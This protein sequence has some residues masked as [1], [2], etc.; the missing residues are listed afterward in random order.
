MLDQ[1]PHG[2]VIT[3]YSYKG[4]TGRTMALANVACSLARNQT[5][6]KGILMIDWDLEAPGLHRFFAPATRKDSRG[7]ATEQLD[8]APG[9]IDF[10]WE[11]NHIFPLSESAQDGHAEETSKALIEKV[12]IQ[13]YIHQTEIAKVYLL[14]AGRFDGEYP[15]R[16]NTFR[17][18][19]FYEKSPDFF[20]ILAEILA[21]QFDYI[22]I[23]SRTGITDTSGICTM[24]MP[25]RL[26]VV[27]VPNQQSL[28]GVADL[29]KRAISY[30]KSSDDLRPLVVFPLPS[31]IESNQ[32]DLREKWRRGDRDENIAGYQSTF[33]ELFSDVYRLDKCILEDYFDNVQIQHVPY[34]AYGEKIAVQLERS[35]DSLSIAKSY[36]SFTDRLLN[37]VNP[38]DY[39]DGTIQKHNNP[40]IYGRA[41]FPSEFAGREAELNR[42]AS[43][44]STGQSIAVIGQP[45]VGKT[46]LLSYLAD[47]TARRKQFGQN[48]DRDIFVYLD[49]LVL[50]GVRTQADFWKY[51]LTP[52]GTL[53]HLAEYEYADQKGYNTFELEQ[54]FGS[55]GR[56]KRKLVLM[57]DEFD[58]LLSHPVL[59]KP[60]F[61]GGLRTLA[62][63]SSGFALVI[64][65]RRS[66][67]QLNRLTQDINPHGS[68]YFNIF[69]ELRLGCL[70]PD[71][72]AALLNTGSTHITAL[73]RQFVQQVSGGHPYLAQAAAAMLWD[74]R[75]EGLAGQE[76]YQFAVQSLY[77]QT[78]PHFADTWNF[79]SSTTRKVVIALALLEV[80]RLLKSRRVEIRGLIEDL[81]DFREE[82]ELL[83]V[84]GILTQTVDGEWRIQQESFLWWFIDEL[85]RNVREETHFSDWLRK[86]NVDNLLT[87][88]DRQSL[89]QAAEEVSLLA[90]KGAMTLMEKLAKD[91]GEVSQDDGKS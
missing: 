34:Y 48:F 7:A 86:Q 70:K 67:E 10:F 20:R 9:L 88:R 36:V 17:W 25:E 69:V 78:R 5:I 56:R 90:G 21:K 51:V 41:L 89:A 38:W 52:L 13:N 62:S 26:V 58:S 15:K 4:G 37:S 46:S 30:R 85:R 16:V 66:L 83:E 12:N 39:S 73:D 74:A 6:S 80:S 42:I 79:W 23:D 61:Y 44:L 45:H 59:N 31:R 72:L 63:R 49:L 77:R 8:F 22:L 33:E 35:E 91:F 27:F 18:D 57:I 24:I 32:P 81:D 84:S 65:S 75:E 55:L 53:E 71:T 40:F 1:N 50:Q 68:P 64:A 60:E 19:A 3:F 54:V 47:T 2:K 82:L 28:T 29:I 43:R 11:C 14:K 76:C 87:E